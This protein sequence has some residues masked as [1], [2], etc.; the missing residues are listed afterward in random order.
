MCVHI[1][2]TLLK[3]LN[4]S[5]LNCYLSCC[6]MWDNVSTCIHTAIQNNPVLLFQ[7]YYYYYFLSDKSFKIKVTLSQMFQPSRIGLL[8]KKATVEKE[9]S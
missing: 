4:M 1:S 6:I 8:N 7:S 5:L 3:M 2:G 9:Q